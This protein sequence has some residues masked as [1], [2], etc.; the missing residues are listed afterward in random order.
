M[1]ELRRCR[2]LLPAY[3]KINRRLGTAQRSAPFT[4]KRS[5]YGDWLRATTLFSS[6][7]TF[8]SRCL[9]PYRRPNTVRR[10]QR[11]T[12]TELRPI[13]RFTDPT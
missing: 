1:P 13:T 4:Q 12:G 11:G 6:R 5:R 2:S 3:A 8:A 9:S 10:S 7:K